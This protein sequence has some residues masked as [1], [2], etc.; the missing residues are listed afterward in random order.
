MSK[1]YRDQ[2]Q[3]LIANSGDVLDEIDKKLRLAQFSVDDDG[4]LVYTE[5]S[6]YSFLVDDNGNLNWEVIENG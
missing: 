2:T 5:N 6:S 3:E 1:G 4:N